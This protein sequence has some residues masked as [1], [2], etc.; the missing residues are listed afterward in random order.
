[1]VAMLIFGYKDKT[2]SAYH[3][4]RSWF[5]SEVH[6]LTCPGKLA[7]LP[8]LDMIYLLLSVDSCWVLSVCECE[9]VYVHAT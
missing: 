7:R 8:V 6:D 1:M 9:C 3:G 2:W 5:F 4:G